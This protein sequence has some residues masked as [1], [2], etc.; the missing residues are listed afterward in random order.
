MSIVK[1]VEHNIVFLA[2]FVGCSDNNNSFEYLY[3]G[4]LRYDWTSIGIVDSCQSYKTRPSDPAIDGA[5]WTPP[6]MDPGGSE[7][8]I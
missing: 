2:D 3:C 8:G 5:P 4:K 6:L 7:V 1:I